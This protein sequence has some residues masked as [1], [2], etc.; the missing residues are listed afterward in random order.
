M[1]LQFYDLCSCS[2]TMVPWYLTCAPCDGWKRSVHFCCA[3]N[4]GLGRAHAQ[5]TSA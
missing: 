5:P 4:A 3:G 1:Q 2:S